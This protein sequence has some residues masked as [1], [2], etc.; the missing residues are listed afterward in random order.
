[1]DSLV[2]E[3]DGGVLT[4]RLNRPEKLNALSVELHEA[5][6]ETW[7]RARDDDTV[8]A[9]LVKGTGERA[10]C[11]GNDTSEREGVPGVEEF[12]NNR[13]AAWDFRTIGLWKPVVASIRGHCIGGGLTLAL[14]CDMRIA[15]D[16]AQFSYPEVAR[17]VPN[18][19]G[20]VMLPRLTNLGGAL[21]L[22][23]LGARIDAD[24]AY[25][26]GLINRVVPVAQLDE[27]AIETAHALAA[28]PTVAAQLTKEIVYRGLE[29]APDT[30]VRM[31]KAFRQISHR[32]AESKEIAVEPVDRQTASS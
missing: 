22:L 1:M 31:G 24:D 18:L 3:F 28:L 5:L 17:G 16:D 2:T 8:R 19:T 30:A 11:V 10:F 27:T 6:V 9:V 26:R 25:R 29:S 4:V 15:S 23:L 7:K 21:E 14:A 32:V 13:I 20:S 12:M